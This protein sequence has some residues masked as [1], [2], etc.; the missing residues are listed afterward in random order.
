MYCDCNNTGEG[1]IKAETGLLP[2]VL[3]VKKREE[4]S[5]QVLVMMMMMMKK[6]KA[7]LGVSIEMC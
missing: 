1:L 2:A 7:Q 4:Q 3:P 5:S 6:K